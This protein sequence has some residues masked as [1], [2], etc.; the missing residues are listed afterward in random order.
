[1]V[2]LLYGSYTYVLNGYAPY[3]VDEKVI[4]NKKNEKIQ[5]FDVVNPDMKS[6]YIRTKKGEKKWI[7]TER[8][9]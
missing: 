6:P 3:G 7:Q 2:W 5:Y 9:Q 1:M 8:P 4:C